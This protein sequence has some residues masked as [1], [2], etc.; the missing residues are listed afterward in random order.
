MVER[1]KLAKYLA[2]D[3]LNKIIDGIPINE[4]SLLGIVSMKV[5]IERQSV[6][7]D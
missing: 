7:F 3:L 1:E 4:G 2:L 5:E 6:I